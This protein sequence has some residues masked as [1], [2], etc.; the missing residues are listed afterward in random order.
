MAIDIL[1]AFDLEPPALD[2]VWP[3]YLAGT[4]GAVFAAGSTG[5]SFWSLEAACCVASPLANKALLGLR[6]EQNGRVLIANAEDPADVVIRRLH[7]IGKHLSPAAR[8]EVAANLTISTLVGE[9]V[10]LQRAGHFR[11]LVNAGTGCRLIVI[12]THNRWSGGA[13]ENDNAAQ[14]A[15]IGLYE[16]VARQTGA[17]VLFLHHVSKATAF[18]GTADVQQAA[19]GASAIIDNCRWAGGMQ[20]MTQDEAKVYGVDADL[21]KHYVRFSGAKENY[22]QPTPEQWLR[23]GE[24]G[25]LAPVVL[26]RPSKGGNREQA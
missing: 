2:F 22:G 4:V 24:G 5:K 23:R 16:A 6:I 9:C 3:G 11:A 12:D 8:A 19:R 26:V 21:R 13:E 7:A 25:V 17:A 1:G 20:T 15:I 18:S 10:N 14:A